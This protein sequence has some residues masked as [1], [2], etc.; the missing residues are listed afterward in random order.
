[1][2]YGSLFKNKDVVDVL[3][4]II[5]KHNTVK[6]ISKKLRQPQS[7]VSMKLAALQE[8]NV[9]IKDKRIFKINWDS[10][11]RMFQKE[12]K[13]YF[14][15]QLEFLTPDLDFDKGIVKLRKEIKNLVR[16]DIPNIFNSER[17]SII[18]KWYS[19]DLLDDYM[20]KMSI[21][22][23]AFLYL[24]VLKRTDMRQFKDF[25]L[26]IMK[27]KMLFDKLGIRNRDEILFSLTEEE[28]TKSIEVV[29]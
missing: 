1:M 19:Q 14:K 15:D 29:P 4:C 7:T 27:I 12:V 18:Y 8:G 5:Q 2:A 24:D 28:L 26:D 10:L 9:V 17:V 3:A 22:D 11:A 23:L 21:S 25:K 13:E 20:E 6:D 16:D